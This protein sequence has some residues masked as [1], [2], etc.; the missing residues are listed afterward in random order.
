MNETISP[1]LLLAAA[2]MLGGGLYLIQRGRFLV[3]ALMRRNRYL[4]T[5]PRVARSLFLVLLTLG[6]VIAGTG[7]RILLTWLR[8]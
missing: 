3:P 6:I 1:T 7:C 5:H 2:L 8:F 4:R